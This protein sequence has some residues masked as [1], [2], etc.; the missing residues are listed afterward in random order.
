[1]G[2]PDD[3]THAVNQDVPVPRGSKSKEGFRQRGPARPDEPV[4][5]EDL[6]PADGERHPM[7]GPCPTQVAHLKTDFPSLG[8]TTRKERRQVAPH[9]SLYQGRVGPLGDS[10]C[11]HPLSVTQHRNAIGDGEDFVELMGNVDE[12]HA[13]GREASHDI[14]EPADFLMGQ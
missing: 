9:H 3:H 2:R 4:Q 8:P 13:S 10:R 6:A 12:R 7:E 1:M 5:T 14:E 11:G